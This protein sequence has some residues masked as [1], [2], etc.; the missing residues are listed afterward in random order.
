MN[1]G[2]IYAVMAEVYGMAA[3]QVSRLTEAQ[4]LMYIDRP[5][6]ADG[7]DRRDDWSQFGLTERDGYL[8]GP[9]HALEAYA[10]YRRQQEAEA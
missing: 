9:S 8:Y 5:E 1:W 6:R 10:E 4:L 3:D 7:A 2:E